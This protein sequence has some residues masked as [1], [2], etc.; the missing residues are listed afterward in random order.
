MKSEIHLDEAV[1]NTERKFGSWSEQG[2]FPA[3]VIRQDGTKQP[4]LFTK[5]QIEIA[6]VR[7]KKNPEDMPEAEK[8][9]WEALF[10]I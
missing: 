10:G 3:F 5:S 4:A 6:V 2:Y 7:A 9:L 8:S 1:E